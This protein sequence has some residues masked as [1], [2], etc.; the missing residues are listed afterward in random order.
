MFRRTTGSSQ[1]ETERVWLWGEARRHEYLGRVA[2]AVTIRSPEEC[3]RRNRI[4]E[5]VLKSS[6]LGPQKFTSLRNLVMLWSE[7]DRFVLGDRADHGEAA[8]SSGSPTHLVAASRP[9]WQGA[10]LL[11]LMER[12][13]ASMSRGVYEKPPRFQYGHPCPDRYGKSFRL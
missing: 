13:R 11:S 6:E 2:Y 4:A 3:C 5:D 12:E 10:A 9:P 7:F 1:L 8:T